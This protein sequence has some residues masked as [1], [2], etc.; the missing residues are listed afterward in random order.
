ME[1]QALHDAIQ[2]FNAEGPNGLHDRPRLV[3]R[4]SSTLVSRPRSK[5]I[6]CADRSRSLS[7]G[8][9]A[10]AFVGLQFSLPDGWGCLR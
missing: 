4:S 6:S 2:H 8:A 3:A 10:S 7:T 5:P 1:R 9:E